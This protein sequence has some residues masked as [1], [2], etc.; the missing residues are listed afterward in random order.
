[1]NKSNGNR[2]ASAVVMD[3]CP[4]TKI[5]FNPLRMIHTEEVVEELRN[6]VRYLQIG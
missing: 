1:M 3:L 6:L 4:G 2:K 5:A